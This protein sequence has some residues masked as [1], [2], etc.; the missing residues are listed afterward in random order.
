MVDV[1]KIKKIKVSDK[2]TLIGKDG[3]NEITVDQWAKKIN[4]INYEIVTRLNP[5]ISRK[6]VS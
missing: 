1:T 6:Y 4:T 3:K 5:L 2:V